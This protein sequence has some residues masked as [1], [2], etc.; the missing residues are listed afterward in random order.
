VKSRITSLNH[1]R[2]QLILSILNISIKVQIMKGKLPNNSNRLLTWATKAFKYF[3]LLLLGFVLVC[4]LSGTFGF[5]AIA[6]Q[7]LL[8][9]D[10]WTWFLRIAV[11]IFFLF[12]IAIIW[13]SSE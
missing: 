8:S 7:V 1:K 12:A 9:P 2:K 6:Y 5:T 3:L 13:E 10:V 11:F 4:V